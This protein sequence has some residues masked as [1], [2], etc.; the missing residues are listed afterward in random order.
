MWF[1]TNMIFDIPLMESDNVPWDKHNLW[2][3]SSHGNTESSLSNFSFIGPLPEADLLG[4]PAKT[5][6]IACTVYELMIQ[7]L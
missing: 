4:E 7:I 6:P 3:I 5:R 1:G 2:N